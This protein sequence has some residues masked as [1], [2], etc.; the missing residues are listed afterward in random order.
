[1][2]HV[3]KILNDY[4]QSLKKEPL[5]PAGSPIDFVPNAK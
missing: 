1:M 4:S 3:G 5:I 2:K